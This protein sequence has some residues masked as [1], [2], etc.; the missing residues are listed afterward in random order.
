MICFWGIPPLYYTK[1][2]P[3]H[4]IIFSEQFFCV[5]YGNPIYVFE[6]YAKLFLWSLPIKTPVLY[7]TGTLCVLLEEWRQNLPSTCQVQCWYLV[8]CQSWWTYMIT[9]AF[10]ICE[11]ILF[12]LK[13]F[14]CGRNP[15]L[16]FIRKSFISLLNPFF[17]EVQNDIWG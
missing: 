5:L 11:R 1:I 4:Y 17:W 12:K 15:R 3:S 2:S 7:H 16:W 8:F 10:F 9:E 13:I 14:N 6:K